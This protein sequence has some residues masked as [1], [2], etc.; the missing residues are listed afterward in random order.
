MLWKAL[1]VALDMFNEGERNAH[2]LETAMHRAV[3]LAPMA[4]LDYA[5]I[6]NAE[7]LEPVTEPKRGDVALIAA[8][9]GKTRLIDNLII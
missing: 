2:R 4:R 3:Q 8:T 7:T 9:I 5:E 6:A 1:S